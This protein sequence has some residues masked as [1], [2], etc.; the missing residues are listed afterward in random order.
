MNKLTESGLF[1]MSGMDLKVELSLLIL[2]ILNRVKPSEEIDSGNHP[3]FSAKYLE[4]HKCSN[5]IRD[6]LHDSSSPV[7]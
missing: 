5:D 6:K 2:T 7:A 4:P 1:N 3:L